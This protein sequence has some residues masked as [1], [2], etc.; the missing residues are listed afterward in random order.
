MKKDLK[1][2]LDISFR[3]CKNSND[4]IANFFRK[5]NDTAWQALKHIERHP[6]KDE[7]EN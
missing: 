2:I 1:T 6:P 5:I 7:E 4:H 3:Y